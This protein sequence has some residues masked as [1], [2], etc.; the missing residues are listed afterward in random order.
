MSKIRKIFG[1]FY[2]YILKPI[3]FLFDPELV[4]D[5]VT[6]L[7]EFLGRFSLSRFLLSKIFVYKNSMLEQQILGI[8][9]PNPVGLAAG[10]DKDAKLA[11][12][13]PHVGFGFEEVGSVTGKP[14]KGN[15]GK[16]LWRMKKSKALVVY[17]GLKNEGAKKVAE[18]LSKFKLETPL[19]VSIAKTNNKETV[20]EE[21]G[22]KD[23]VRSYLEFRNRKIGDYFT[24]NISCPNTFGGEPFTD[25]Q[26]LDRL[27]LKLR[28]AGK[29]DPTPFFLKLPAELPK[30]QIDQIIE[31]ARRYKI[32]GLICTNLAKSRDNKNIKDEVPSVG[33]MS[34][35]V[36]GEMSDDLISYI[37]QKTGKEFVIVGCGG[38]F[39]AEDA[40][41]KIKNGASLLQLITGLIFEGPQLIGEINEGLVY[42]LKKDGYKNI[43]EAVGTNKILINNK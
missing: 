9:F 38:I 22:I 6:F 27:L 36:V 25:P 17:Y 34:G 13:I 19:G 23:Y 16:R 29:G 12:I 8:N 26:K 40:Y 41:R 20:S 42:L 1:L 14:C 2:R 30:S 15:E 32:G 10:F 18:R 35:K 4:H 3:F 7:G 5:R 28:E 39:N 43:S 24:V 33:G 11:R 37:Y 21:D 31:V